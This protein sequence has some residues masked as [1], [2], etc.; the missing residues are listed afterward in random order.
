MTRQY[1]LVIADKLEY[2]LGF[3]HYE[4]PSV[5]AVWNY[6][7]ITAENT[8]IISQYSTSNTLVQWFP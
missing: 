2:F 7:S 1:F 5:T 4:N 8:N 3:H 6:V